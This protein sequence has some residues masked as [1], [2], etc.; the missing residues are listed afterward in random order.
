[1]TS[2]GGRKDKPHT[3]AERTSLIR[4]PKVQAS[5]GGRKDKPHTVAE[6]T[7]LIRW[8]KVQT[9][10]W[11]ISRL[12]CTFLSIAAHF[13]PTLAKFLFSARINLRSS[14]IP[15]TV[16][17]YNRR[18]E[19]HKYR[20]FVLGGRCAE[21]ALGNETHSETRCVLIVVALTAGR[22]HRTHCYRGGGPGTRA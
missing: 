20:R 14:E 2:Y 16:E 7:N 3:V 12:R 18:K 19:R 15:S 22:N 13:S 1:M 9:I 5:Y 8:P 11:W 10:C 6:R 4:W 17:K 21:I